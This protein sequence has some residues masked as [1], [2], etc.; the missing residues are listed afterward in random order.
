MHDAL[1]LKSPLRELKDP[2]LVVGFAVRQRAGRLAHV[3][4][5]YLVE[6]WQAELVAEIDPDDFLDFTV[7]RPE[8]R[9]LPRRV[10]QAAAGVQQEPVRQRAD[11]GEQVQGVPG[12]P[13][14]VPRRRLALPADLRV[15]RCMAVS[16][17]RTNFGFRAA[18][19]KDDGSRTSRW[20]AWRR[21]G[22]KA[23]REEERVHREAGRRGGERSGDLRK[24]ALGESS[25]RASRLTVPSVPS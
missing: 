12:L 20:V 24:S 2:V 8:Q 10:Q 9:R 1:L 21:E 14:E 17:E 11:R 6:A 13:R 5:T 22:R 18:F 3:A 25:E 23:G 4:L 16:H 15:A 7:R 19:P